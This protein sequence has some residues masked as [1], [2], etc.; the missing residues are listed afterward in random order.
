MFNTEGNVMRIN[1]KSSEIDTIYGNT[2]KITCTERK[3]RII[4]SGTSYIIVA[5]R[6]LDEDTTEKLLH[7]DMELK[8]FLANYRICNIKRTLSGAKYSDIDGNRL[9][10]KILKDGMSNKV[11]PSSWEKE[12]SES[13]KNRREL[14]LNTM[15]RR[16]VFSS[17]DLPEEF[18]VNDYI[19]EIEKN[20]LNVS[21]QRM[22]R[23]DLKWL[24]KE[25]KIEMIGR[26]EKGACIYKR[27][28]E[29]L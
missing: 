17:L 10:Q 1:K 12:E 25:G 27:K 20:G 14:I 28:K 22:A 13:V 26:N 8:T 23:D 29:K 21:G 3:Y 6:E 2:L 16:E 5:K 19:S 9:V 4:D 11:P 18:L 15:K 24:T 7:E